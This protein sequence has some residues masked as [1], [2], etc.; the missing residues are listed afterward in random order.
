MTFD[1]RTRIGATVAVVAV[2]IAWWEFGPRTPSDWS[3]ADL[4]IIRSLSIDSLPP[5]PPDP[6][7]AVA[8]NATAASFGHH[9]FFDSRLSLNGAVSCA[10]CHQPGRQFTGP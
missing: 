9:L 7:N 10:T 5:L 2:L 8:D 4:D 3:E 6:S 1:R